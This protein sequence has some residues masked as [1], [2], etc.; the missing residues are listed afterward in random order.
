MSACAKRGPVRIASTI[1]LAGFA[2]LAACGEEDAATP[3]RPGSAVVSLTGAEPPGAVLITLTGP[4]LDAAQAASAGTELSWRLVSAGEMRVVVAGRLE[5]G[6]LLRVSVPDLE[7]VDEYGGLVLEVADRSGEL[8]PS[9]S[10][11]TVTF[12]DPA[13]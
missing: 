10:A 12:R 4:G 9:G 5:S 1:L 7:R 3:P 13:S 11:Y 2:T 8:L 6:P